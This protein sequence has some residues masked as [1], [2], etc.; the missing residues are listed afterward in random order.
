MVD[1]MVLAGIGELVAIEVE[2]SA[3]AHWILLGR[4]AM[5]VFCPS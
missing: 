5:S 1:V 3:I 2:D 4:G